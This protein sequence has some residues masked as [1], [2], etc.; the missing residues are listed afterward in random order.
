MSKQYNENNKSDDKLFSFLHD[1]NDEQL[2][3]LIN[4]EPPKVIA[5]ALDQLGN[6]RQLN[7]LER[8]DNNIKNSVI[9]QLGNLK[10]IPLEGIVNVAKELKNKI[11]FIPGPK[12]FTRGGPKSIA[13]ILNQMSSEEAEQ[14]LEQIANEDA[15]LY[16]AIK[17]YFLSFDDLLEMPK[18]IMST[19]WRNPEIDIDDLSKAFKG[20]DESIIN[21]IVPYLSKRNQKMYEA[22]DKPLS[23]KD[24]D[25]SQ[26][27]FVE[28][29]RKMN[30]DGDIN[31]EELL[32][33]ADDL[34]E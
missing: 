10:D 30:D 2:F 27:K 34:V 5:L 26:R 3:Y 22:Y 13:T 32:A 31:L 23:K 17:K 33:D 28:L 16:E 8:F 20:L 1:L 9:M 29:A 4:T 19:Y 14:Y 12:E 25:K 7:L 11:P 15:E 21:N 6:K 24:I 18:H